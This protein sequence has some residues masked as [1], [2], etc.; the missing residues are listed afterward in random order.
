MWRKR[1]EFHCSQEMCARQKFK[2][3]AEYYAIAR[4][5]RGRH[6]RDFCLPTPFRSDTPRVYKIMT[7]AEKERNRRRQEG[8]ATQIHAAL[9]YNRRRA[10]ISSGNVHF[11][12][13][14]DRSCHRQA[15]CSSCFIIEAG[16]SGLTSAINPNECFRKVIKS[17][18]DSCLDR[19]FLN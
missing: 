7:W 14:S 13:Y 17:W 16:R 19:K 1:Q 4:Q 18:G 11:A 12:T 10:H 6:F 15:S 3:L 8:V 5:M 9:T 2:C